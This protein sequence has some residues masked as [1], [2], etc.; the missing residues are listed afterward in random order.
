MRARAPRALSSRL[1]Q[2]QEKEDDAQQSLFADGLTLSKLSDFFVRQQANVRQV[3]P[4]KRH[5]NQALKALE[6]DHKDDER[7]HE[8]Y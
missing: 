1:S 3:W 5:E 2:G 6:E 8:F 7:Q 4:P